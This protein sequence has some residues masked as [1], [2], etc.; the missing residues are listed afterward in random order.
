[1]VAF[2]ILLTI[3]YKPPQVS[4]DDEKFWEINIWAVFW[5]ILYDFS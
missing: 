3:P 5:I 2:T 4:F 1:V